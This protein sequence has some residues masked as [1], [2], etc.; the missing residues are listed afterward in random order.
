M[1]KFY[2]PNKSTYYF[3]KVNTKISTSFRQSMLIS[4]HW[5]R[6]PGLGYNNDKLELPERLSTGIEFWF[7]N[8][9]HGG[10]SGNRNFIY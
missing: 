1:T 6:L 4:W 5:L 8:L 9:F 3:F 7:R 10:K 2:C